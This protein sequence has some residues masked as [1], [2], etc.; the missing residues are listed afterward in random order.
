MSDQSVS[1]TDSK[2]AY[3]SQLF[4][5]RPVY[6]VKWFKNK[7]AVL[8]ALWS[9]LVMPAFYLIK[10]GMRNEHES[11]DP[12]NSSI[13]GIT[14]LSTMLLYP[15]GGWLADARL[16]RYKT[17]RYSM[18]MM[19][20]CTL[21]ITLGEV[22]RYLSVTYENHIRVWVFRATCV[23]MAT[24]FAGFQSN[25]VQLGIDQLIDA[26]SDEITS[27]IFWYLL[28]M[29]IGALCM[30]FA[31]ECIAYINS[32]FCIQ[33]LYLTFSLTLGLCLDFFGQ[34]WLFKESVIRKSIGNIL[35]VTRYVMKNRKRRYDFVSSDDELPS[36]FD[37]AKYQY[38]GPF[39]ATQVNNVRRFLWMLAILTT[40][41]TFFGAL[42]P[43]D[44][45]RQK[46]QLRWSRY[47]D[48]N[49]MIGCYQKLILHNEDSI[50]IV[51]LCLSYEFLIRPFFYKCLPNGSIVRKFVV[52]TVLFLLWIV[53]LLTIEVVAYSK[54]MVLSNS[55]QILDNECI[56]NGDAPKVKIDRIWLVIPDIFGGLSRFVLLIAAVEFICAQ[57]PSTLKGLMF[58]TAYA[59]FGLST[60]IHASIGI[61]FLFNLH[62]FDWRPLSCGIWYFFLEGGITVCV[63][64]VIVILVRL[65]RNF[66]RK[67]N[68][69]AF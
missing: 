36:Q 45:A 16:G 35:K 20:T 66:T 40:C 55:S 61:P 62:K 24:A 7:G 52:G 21:V 11:L 25:I 41:V 10:A 6:R 23:I 63:L 28:T 22:L 14:V 69:N 13:A 15:I 33:T 49:G 48:V 65:Y 54:E 9:F 34:Q 19:W 58:G 38:G 30:N 42:M 60:I 8:I 2:L 46:V 1:M 67:Q 44:Y 37:V 51:F 57:A 29:Y 56:F 43:V 3:H 26:S 47:S 32:M 27:F 53:S 50:F 31:T 18:W 17:V 12:L 59:I 68:R 64:I 39:T 4:C 5:C